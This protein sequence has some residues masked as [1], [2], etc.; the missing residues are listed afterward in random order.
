MQTQTR[1]DIFD[2]ARRK[3]TIP[4]LWP[5]LQLEGQPKASCRSPFR[6]DRSPSFSIFDDGKAW[7]DHGTGEGGDTIEF[8]KTALQSDYKAVRQWL[9]E[10]MGVTQPISAAPKANPGITQKR[11]QWPSRLEKCSGDDWRQLADARGYSHQAIHLMDQCGALRFTDLEGHRAFVVT[12]ERMR[13]AEIRRLDGKDWGTG[14]KAFPLKGVEKSLLLGSPMIEQP[15]ERV[16]LL[17]GATDYLS[18]IDLYTQYRRKHGGKTCWV[19]VALLGANCRKLHPEDA[20]RIRGKYVRIVPDGDE[21]GDQM[22]DHWRDLLRSHGCTIDVVNLPPQT[23]LS[24]HLKT[25]DPTE[26]F[27]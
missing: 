20:R 14:K 23:D 18:A 1:P 15:T 11:I 7:C 16:M 4:D 9:V 6:D 10:R 12:D 2:E 13:I 5:M 24:D 26:L 25:I 22:A 21:A 19:P 3:F 8:I 27:S 17:E